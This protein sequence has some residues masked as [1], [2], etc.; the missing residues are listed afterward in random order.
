M[1]ITMMMTIMIA[2]KII[3]HTNVKM[4]TIKCV[5]YQCKRWLKMI[6]SDSTLNDLLKKIIILTRNVTIMGLELDSGGTI[7]EPA[8]V[9]L[10]RILYRYAFRHTFENLILTSLSL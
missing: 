6:T 5:N 7:T 4:Y 9:M 2:M 1:M 3:K 8:A 10:Q